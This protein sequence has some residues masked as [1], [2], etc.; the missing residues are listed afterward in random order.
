MIFYSSAGNSQL[1]QTRVLY[2]SLLWEQ[3]QGT[4][5]KLK[6]YPINAF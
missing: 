3:N 1:Q 5:E 6:V 2:A 4:D